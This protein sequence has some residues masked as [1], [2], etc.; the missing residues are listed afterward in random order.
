LTLSGVLLWLT[1]IAGPVRLATGLLQARSHLD[2]AEKLLSRGTFKRVRYEIF[3]AEAAGRRAQAGLESDSPLLDLATLVPAVEDGLKEV[4]H[5]V[6]AGRHSAQ[7]AEDALSLGVGLLRGE[8]KVIAPDPDGE[9]KVVVLDRIEEI[10]DIVGHARSEVVAARDELAAVDL[11]NLPRRVRPGIRDGIERAEETRKLLARTEA[12]FELLPAILGGEGRRTYL[13]GFQNSAE[14]RG[15]GGAMLQISCLFMDEGKADI[16]TREDRRRLAREGTNETGAEATAASNCAGTV[17]NVDEKR[18]QIDIPLPE[19]AWYVRAIED[20]QRF[21]NSN[22]SPDW[23]LSARLTVAY[24]QASEK[25]FPP[26]DGV[27]AIDPIAVRNLM[28]GVGAFNI[29]TGNRI[30]ASKV[31]NFLLSKAYSSFP[32]PQSRRYVL[33]EVVER[34]FKRMFKP[35]RPTEVVEGIGRSLVTKHIQIWMS[36]PEEQAFI[37]RMD[38][39]GAISNR[40]GDDYLYVVE[41]NVGGNKLDYTATQRD[42]MDIRLSNRD[43][44]V[45]TEVT[46]HNGVQLPQPRWVLGDSDSAHRP[47]MNLYVPGNAE[48]IDARVGGKLCTVADLLCKGR[49]DTPAPA[50]WDG[51]RPPEHEEAGKKVWSATMQIPVGEE[52]SFGVDYRV[53]GAVQTRGN[54]KVYRLAIQR[55]PKVRPQDLAIRLR[56]PK[57]ATNIHAQGFERDGRVLTYERPLTKDMVLEVT[58]RS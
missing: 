58:W 44:T 9:G 10:G 22:W 13:L 53:P 14:L 23:P 31:V 35:A 56:V 8:N 17:Y 25:K 12:G 18:R 6:A 36:D 39:D 28:P 41:Q 30:S 54:T 47:M 29:S 42:E 3:A 46:I 45:S 27:I 48:L 11:H 26:I 15:T 51:D 55:Q 21:G 37:R 5:L 1:M 50:V 20:A 24:A 38:W 4:P 52:A 7:A 33:R 43:A 40:D 2:E 16:P 19:D 32:V 49:L 34:F 57:G